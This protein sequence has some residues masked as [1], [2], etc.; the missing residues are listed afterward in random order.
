[1]GDVWAE[2]ESLNP[3]FPSIPITKRAATGGLER[4]TVGRSAHSQLHFD[5]PLI[6]QIHCCLIAEDPEASAS[7]AGEKQKLN[8]K[9]QDTSCNGTFVNGQRVGMGNSQ[10]VRDGDIIS[11]VVIP[12]QRSDGS[13]A[14]AC[15]NAEG[16]ARLAFG[17]GSSIHVSLPPDTRFV[18]GSDPSKCSP[19]QVVKDEWVDP[20]S[21]RTGSRVSGAHCNIRLPAAAPRQ[22]QSTGRVAPVLENTGLNG[23]WLNFTKLN[24]GESK[25]L[26]HGDLVKLV[27]PDT[28]KDPG[29]RCPEN[30]YFT[31]HDTRPLEFKAYRLRLRPVA[32]SADAS[33]KGAETEGSGED[34]EDVASAERAEASGGED[35]VDWAKALDGEG[36]SRP[37]F[38]DLFDLCGQLGEGTF[39]RV[40]AARH[41]AS[42]REVAVKVFDVKKLRLVTTNGLEKVGGY[43]AC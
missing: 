43:D 39:A 26:R 10:P 7:A 18:L 27:N 16:W 40:Y 20:R 35:E 19:G 14:V 30:L 29:A 5:D 34:A 31:F 11:L 15:R 4:F 36:A 32:V 2:L 13:F 24:K 28:S 22:S 9:L 3:C 38:A 8:V 25:A 12:E 42:G 23:S 17:D 41:K 1:M 33:S 6:S 37:A 21:G